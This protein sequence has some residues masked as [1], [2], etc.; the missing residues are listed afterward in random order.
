[1]DVLLAQAAAELIKDPFDLWA[2]RLKDIGVP[3]SVCA[4]ILW[5]IYK[6]GP[7][8]AEAHVSTLTTVRETQ[9]R[10]SDTFNEMSRS[11]AKIADNSER[12]AELNQQQALALAALAKTDVE[13]LN[14]HQRTHRCLLLLAE[15][16]ALESTNPAAKQKIEE[17]IREVQRR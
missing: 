2:D 14:E 13:H 11:S 5:F 7:K 4:L 3:L 16:R 12:L 15:A 8:L 10:H 1:M 9:K 17:A 6:Y